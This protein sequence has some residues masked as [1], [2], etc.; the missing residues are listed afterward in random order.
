[1]TQARRAE[2]AAQQKLEKNSRWRSYAQDQHWRAK[3]HA[4][5]AKELYETAQKAAADAAN[6]ARVH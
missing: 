4:L 6:A 2:A 1:V 3:E 5:N